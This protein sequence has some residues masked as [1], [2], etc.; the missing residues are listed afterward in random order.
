[1][2]DWVC[3]IDISKWQGEVDWQT[4]AD[5]GV[6]YVYMRAFN[7]TRLDEQLEANAAGARQYGIPFGL[8]TYWRP[9]EAA[10]VQAQRL[11][12]AHREF[13]ATLIPMIDVEHQDDKSPSEIAQSV[14]D[15]VRFVGAELKC[16][17]VI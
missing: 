9:R 3:G 4:V 15:G 12:D 2:A 11:T 5:S 13:G 8:Y 7:G 10:G 16:S 17:P 6:Q 1:M 14:R